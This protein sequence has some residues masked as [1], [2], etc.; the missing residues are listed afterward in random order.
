MGLHALLA[1]AAI[2]FGPSP[3]CEPLDYY[4]PAAPHELHAHDSD[5]GLEARVIAE[6]EKIPGPI[7]ALIW[8]HEPRPLM[9][10]TYEPPSQVEQFSQLDPERLNVMGRPTEDSAAFIT[11][12]HE[13]GQM[14]GYYN[15]ARVAQGSASQNAILH[16]FG[17]IVYRV[18]GIPDDEHLLEAFREAGGAFRMRIEHHY[19]RNEMDEAL[20]DALILDEMFAEAF[21]FAYAHPTSRRVL[22]ERYPNLARFMDAM[23][24]YAISLLE[25]HHGFDYERRCELAHLINPPGWEPQTILNDPGTP[26]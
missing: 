19:P 1:S 5:P 25:E 20:Y 21:A 7:R 18:L 12:W 3:E 11:R 15:P 23:E 13:S 8:W 26:D 22:E 4:W 16:E 2:A 14:I 17:H 9:V 24:P 10:V 6:Q